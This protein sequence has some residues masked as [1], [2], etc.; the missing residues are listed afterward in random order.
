[1]AEV[2]AGVTLTSGLP[3]VIT[4]ANGVVRV[5]D[6]AAFPPPSGGPRRS[7]RSTPRP[8]SPTSA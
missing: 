5:W 4:A 3:A 1:M 8:R 7:A 2:V 6:A